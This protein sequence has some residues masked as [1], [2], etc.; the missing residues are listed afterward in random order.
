MTNFNPLIPGVS[1]MLALAPYRALTAGETDLVGLLPDDTLGVVHIRSLPAFRT[2]WNYNPLA[3]TWAEPEVQAFIAPALTKYR[4]ENSG[5]LNEVIQAETGMTPEELMDL[6][7]GEIAIVLPNLLSLVS[8]DD[9]EMP[10]LLFLAQIGD[11]PIPIENL[12]MRL[13]ENE[14]D[15]IAE[16]EFQG[17][18]IRTV[19]LLNEEAEAPEDSFSWVIFDGLVALGTK[20]TDVQQLVDN[21]KRGGAEEPLVKSPGFQAI[22]RD[23]PEAHIV[24]YLSL[25]GVIQHALAEFREAEAANGPDQPSTL[26]MVGMT[27]EGI[28]T[29]LGLDKLTTLYGAGVLGRDATLF[30][31]GIKWSERPEI[32]R[33]LAYGDPPAPRPDFIPDSWISVSSSR[34]SVAQMY[35][36]L[37]EVLQIASPALV[38]LLEMKIAGLNQALGIDIERDLIGNFG[39]EIIQAEAL[40][41]RGISAENANPTEQLWA[42]SIKDADTAR[43]MVDALTAMAPGLGQALESREYLGETIYSMLPPE[44]PGGQPAGAPTSPGFAYAITRN[45][46]FISVGG[47]SMLESAIQGLDGASNSIWANQKIAEALGTLPPGESMIAYQDTKQIVATVYELITKGDDWFGDSETQGADED[48]A[49]YDMDAKPSADVLAKHWGLGVSAVYI[50]ADGV[51][52]VGRLNHV[53]SDDSEH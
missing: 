31:T 28:V 27:P 38:G 25:G 26:A 11:D 33:I 30:S 14:S 37:K 29:S 48:E 35:V 17:E 32:M 9:D 34:F 7:P 1:L 23:D 42:V 8:D 24:L 20:I 18:T 45:H 5:G 15:E 13:S 50:E 19:R 41:D 39:D 46:V 49:L 6:F 22:Y 12:F 47:P 43:R 10:Q 52:S 51:R 36:G 16:E 4:E 44:V 3:K 40:T 2:H 21:A 53:E